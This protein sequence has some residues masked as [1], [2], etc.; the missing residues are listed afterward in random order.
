MV[1]GITAVAIFASSPWSV[2]TTLRHIGAARNC[3]AARAMGL[4]PA[5]KGQPGY[6][7]KHDR[8]KD[9]IACEPWPRERR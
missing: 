9:G 3:D 6:Y 5:L 4:A 8:D 1:I 2:L 7:A